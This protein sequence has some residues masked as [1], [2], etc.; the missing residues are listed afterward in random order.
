MTALNEL[1]EA[2]QAC[3]NLSDLRVIVLDTLDELGETVD[4]H[5]Q[6]FLAMADSV[7]RDESREL[8]NEADD[9]AETL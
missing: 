5:G 7:S 9:I 8:L 4:D 1:Y 3:D 6:S 2:L